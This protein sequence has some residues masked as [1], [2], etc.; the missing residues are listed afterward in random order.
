[1]HQGNKYLASLLLAAT[2]VAPFAA[3]A[4]GVPQDDHE[5]REEQ[6]RVYDRRHKDYHN[7]DRREDESYRRWLEERHHGYVQFERLKH[8]DQQAYWQWRHDHP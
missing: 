7:W 6:R 5:R 1:V 3:V 4:K 8:R 2:L